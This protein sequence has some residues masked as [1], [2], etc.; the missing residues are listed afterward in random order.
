MKDSKLV[1]SSVWIAYFFNGMHKEIIDSDEMLLLSVLSLFEIRKSLSKNKIA[2]DKIKKSMEFVKRRSLIIEVNTEIAEK[3]VDF[4]LENGLPI[5]DSIIYATS[6]MNESILVTLDN[7][8][9]GLKG[10]VLK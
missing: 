7:D 2:E 9:R 5:I 4:S 10:V 1:D 3:A 8:F 6:V